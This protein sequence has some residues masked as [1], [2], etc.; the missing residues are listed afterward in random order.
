MEAL[1]FVVADQ[2]DVAHAADGVAVLAAVLAAVLDPD[3]VE[4]PEKGAWRL[5]DARGGRA[6]GF[7]GVQ[8]RR[9]FLKPRQLGWHDRIAL[10]RTTFP[11]LDRHA[12]CPESRCNACI[13]DLT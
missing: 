10:D 9:D 13:L 6:V 11:Q 4:F 12:R 7:D 1:D 2:P 8:C 5:G 3:L